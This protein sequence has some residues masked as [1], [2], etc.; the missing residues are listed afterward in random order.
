MRWKLCERSAIS[1]SLALR[2]A[3]TPITETVQ[4]RGGFGWRGGWGGWRGGWGGLGIGLATGAIIGA[5]LSTRMLAMGMVILPTPMGILI[6]TL[7]PI[8]ALVTASATCL[9]TPTGEVTRRGIGTASAPVGGCLW[10]EG[11]SLPW[12]PLRARRGTRRGTSDDP[13]GNSLVEP[14]L[15]RKGSVS[16]TD[17]PCDHGDPKTTASIV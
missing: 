11:R 8:T 17:R 9:V 1:Q 13:P 12:S 15:G 14:Q 6:A 4:W 5:A 2:D 16:D 7:L 10:G 3:A